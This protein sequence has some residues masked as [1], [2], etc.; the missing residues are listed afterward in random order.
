MSSGKSDSADADGAAGSCGN[1]DEGP[2]TTGKASICSPLL[3]GNCAGMCTG[4][5]ARVDVGAD[6]GAGV[7]A[8]LE[9]AMPAPRRSSG[10][11]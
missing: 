1:D 3:V 10:G 6:V 7:G 9:R 8:S 4:A 11:G 2:L 5:R